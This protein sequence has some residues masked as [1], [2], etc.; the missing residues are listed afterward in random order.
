MIVGGILAFWITVHP[1]VIAALQHFASGLL[2]GA[3]GIEMVPAAQ[4]ATGLGMVALAIGFILG[5]SLL[6]FVGRYDF[7]HWK[8]CYKMD[9]E[10]P[11]ISAKSTP[12]SETRQVENEENPDTVTIHTERSLEIVTKTET[13]LQEPGLVD[14]KKI[15]IGL[16]F[17][18][19]VDASI[20]GL[21]IGVNALSG[22]SPGLVTSIGLA[23][24]MGLLGISTCS[25]LRKT[26]LSLAKII[27]LNLALPFVI[28]IAGLIGAT[29][30]HQVS[31]DGEIAVTAFGCAGL[32]YL[33]TEELMIEAHEEE[34]SNRWFVT[35][36][37]FIGFLFVV[38][39]DKLMALY[40]H[41]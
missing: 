10:V 19:V 4:A 31:G 22:I 14:S 5:F 23:I 11:F 25:T 20:D 15:P 8:K 29:V 12:R 33:V 41:L 38:F 26:R 6:L 30:L 2:I 7:A 3:V 21:L 17:A 36:M 40:V 16:V 28:L 32:L 35:V 27:S 24:E 37:F 34:E 39:L 9:E 18:V 1:N 13:N